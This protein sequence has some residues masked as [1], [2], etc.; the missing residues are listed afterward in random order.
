MHGWQ[1]AR[2]MIWP[3]VANTRWRQRLR[4]HE[5]ASCPSGTAAR[6]I[7]V[8][9]FIANAA[10]CV[11]AWFAPKEAKGSLLRPVFFSVLIRFSHRALR[12]WRAPVFLGVP[13]G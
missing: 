6:V 2:V 4:S 10:I 7:Q 9:V 8:S 1:R 3:A 11:Q 5:A 13:P 12:R